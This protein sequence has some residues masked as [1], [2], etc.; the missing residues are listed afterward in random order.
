M[1]EKKIER[2]REDQNGI[3]L[4]KINHKK[5]EDE[6]LREKKRKE[7]EGKETLKWRKDWR[8]EMEENKS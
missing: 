7:E 2:V 1:R 8:K 3:R 5:E 6:E 4:Q